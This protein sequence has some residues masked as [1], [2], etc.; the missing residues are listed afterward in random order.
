MTDREETRLMWKIL[1]VD[2]VAIFTLWVAVI[3]YIIQ[4]SVR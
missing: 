3:A 4:Q 1:V 2:T